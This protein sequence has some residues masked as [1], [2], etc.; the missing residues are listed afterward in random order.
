MALAQKLVCRPIEQNRIEEIGINSCN[1]THQL[2]L[3]KVY[4]YICR[5]ELHFFSYLSI[6]NESKAL[7]SVKLETLKPPD[8][9]TDKK[10]I[11]M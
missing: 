5:I 6:K 11:K 4:V 8:E 2:V 9:T 3:R 10:Y 1:Y 7:I